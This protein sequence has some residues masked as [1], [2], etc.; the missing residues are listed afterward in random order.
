MRTK[1]SNIYERVIYKVGV[2]GC[3]ETAKFSSHLNTNTPHNSELFFKMPIAGGG[4]ADVWGDD[5]DDDDDDDIGEEETVNENNNKLNLLQQESETR[6]ERFFNA[7][8]RDGLDEGRTATVQKGFNEGYKTG[9]KEGFEFGRV[10]G[11][12]RSLKILHN[13][14]TGETT[15]EKK[16][17]VN[18][19]DSL[20][21]KHGI[22]A[23]SSTEARRLKFVHRTK[24]ED[25]E[26]NE[27]AHRLLTQEALE[28]L[29]KRLLEEENVKL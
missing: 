27:E 28:T 25:E 19:N 10:R 1:R 17:H 9:F 4:T 26:V 21:S 22:V 6:R 2:R 24:S 14:N 16:M 29:K 20:I 8:Y 7:G 18:D 23:L 5:D 11:A 15:K 13:N 3:G 12:V